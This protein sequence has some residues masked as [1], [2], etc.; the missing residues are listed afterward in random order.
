[1]HRDSFFTDVFAYRLILHV[2]IP[3]TSNI[4]LSF[5]SS[6]LVTL[7]YYEGLNSDP[8]SPEWT[9]LHAGWPIRFR[10]PQG[11]MAEVFHKLAFWNENSMVCHLTFFFPSLIPLIYSRHCKKICWN[12]SLQSL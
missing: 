9:H 12:G 11:A 8:E 7:G 5:Q 6:P 2:E 3:D 4:D 10:Q 1:M